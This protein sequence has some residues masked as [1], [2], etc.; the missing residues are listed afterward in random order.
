MD[1]L[2]YL[3]PPKS[4]TVVEFGCGD[5]RLGAAFRQIRPECRYLGIEA[6]KEQLKEAR[7]RLTETIEGTLDTVKPE[8]QGI[9]TVDCFVYRG[10]LPEPRSLAGILRR[11]AELLSDDGQ[12]IFWLDYTGYIRHAVDFLRG[13]QPM[14]PAL[15]PKEL[16]SILSA[17]GMTVDRVQPVYAKEDEAWRKDETTAAFLRAFAELC[18]KHGLGAKTDVWA[19]AFL[20]RAVK[21]PAR[22]KLLVQSLLGEALVTARVRLNEP[23]RFLS[24]VPGFEARAEQG[25]IRIETAEAYPDRILIRQR[26]TLDDRADGLRMIRDIIGRGYLLLYEMDDSPSRW[27]AAHEKTGWLD[28]AGSHAVQVSTPALA[29]EIRPHNPEVRVFL[30]HLEYLPEKR[31]YDDRPEAPVTIFFGALNR[32]EDWTDIMPVLNQM[33]R[34]YG[35]RLRFRVLADQKFFGALQTPHKEFVGSKDY[36]E[37]RYVP[38]PVYLQTLRS[39]D[40]ALLP[41]HDTLFNRAKSDL[42]FI[43]SAGHG[44]AVLASPTVYRATVR[45]GETGFLYRDPREFRERLTLL[46]EDSARR[47]SLADAAYE[48]VKHERLLSGHY[49]ERLDWYKEL[50]ERRE[51]LTRALEERVAKLEDK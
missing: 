44:A 23:N 50:L 38:Y 8:E 13:E 40:I 5:G 25:S 14:R 26:T 45:D 51:E 30:N 41:L 37:G 31:I 48:Y 19:K 6:E 27:A 24:T 7:Q 21:Q 34:H 32:E 46:I 29:E 42:K 35:E 39:A 36:Y 33:A 1:P 17:A 28:F 16:I 12:M 20:L 3:I 18:K 2:V 4:R 22:R 47:R 11:H 49:E 15:P 43:E 9:S 10:S